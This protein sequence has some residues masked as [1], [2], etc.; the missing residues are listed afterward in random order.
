MAERPKRGVQSIYATG[1]ETGRQYIA[2]LERGAEEHDTFMPPPKRSHLKKK[3]FKE[4]EQAHEYEAD[5]ES[6]EEEDEETDDE[7]DDEEADV[8]EADDEECD[9][10]DESDNEEDEA[11]E[12]DK[13]NFLKNTCRAIW[14]KIT[15]S[16]GRKILA[17]D[18]YR[19]L[20]SLEAMRKHAKW[21]KKIQLNLISNA[22]TVDIVKVRADVL[23]NMMMKRGFA[24]AMTTFA[25][26]IDYCDDHH[27]CD[28]A[29]Y[30]PMKVYN[31]IPYRVD[32][33]L[34]NRE[35]FL[36]QGH[37]RRNLPE[38]TA[39]EAARKV[40]SQIG[41]LA[42]IQGYM[43]ASRLQKSAEIQSA[44]GKYKYAMEQARLGTR[45][46]AQHSKMTTARVTKDER[47]RALQVLLDGT[48]RGTRGKNVDLFHMRT[49]A[50][51][52]LE[53][54]II[55]R[56]QDIRSIHMAAMTAHTIDD[57]GPASCTAVCASI[58]H[59]K[60]NT[61][62]TEFVLSWISH[63]D[64]MQCSTIAIANYLVWAIDIYRL[65]ILNEMRRDLETQPAWINSGQRKDRWQSEWWSYRLVFGQDPKKELS[66]DIHLDGENTIHEAA[67]YQKKSKKTSL[68]RTNNAHIALERGM[69]TTDLSHYGGWAT[70]NSSAI[71][72]YIDTAVKVDSSMTMNGWENY[73]KYY[74]ARHSPDIPDAL[75][76]RIFPEL[77]ELHTLAKTTYETT[78]LDLSAV[79]FCEL[80]MYL[81][82]IFLEG[83]VDL[84]ARYPNLPP[85]VHPVFDTREWRV[86][87]RMEPDSRK[88]R[89]GKFKLREQDPNVIATLD[90]IH[91]NMKSMMD[92]L[93][94]AGSGAGL[95]G[96]TG[97]LVIDDTSADRMNVPVVPT[98]TTI[99][100][101]Y[102]FWDATLR[103]FL[104]R[105]YNRVSWKDRKEEAKRV[106]K[107]KP[108][109]LYID[110]VL[111]KSESDSETSGRSKIANAIIEKL[112]DIRKQKEASYSA[113]VY[114]F[115]VAIQKTKVH[116][117]NMPSHN[118]EEL[119]AAL[120][121][122]D[123]PTLPEGKNVKALCELLGWK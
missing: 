35:D 37:E 109:C 6:D 20:L 83:A 46:F 21:Y 11:T 14:P 100:A 32:H 92:K 33:I 51:K 90:K 7:S 74:C 115:K 45:D 4:Q 61:T 15:Q 16:R 110:Y 53:Q 42:E 68:P 78:Q 43:P 75:C 49:Y 91:D 54:N 34:K 8:E 79:K 62:N 80:L 94:I 52:Y 5:K 19:D 111:S 3:A 121:A 57:V 87:S 31:F 18:T 63:I 40:Q 76:R 95:Q 72:Y 38:E 108:F 96:Q 36:E 101:T 114:S 29:V 30:N 86:W 88:I 113:F 84:R 64:P 13:W 50:I 85:Y 67:G 102:R 122:H 25:I 82:R 28:Y 117:K 73:K 58:R 2:L 44:I 41:K 47:A 98:F 99:S 55:R 103:P 69:N 24:S 12:L 23:R 112:E 89:D 10:D 116:E 97:G 107:F 1:N 65:D 39:H 9:D 119:C 22:D 27:N 120:E 60:E 66:Y 59:V 81:R 106:D 26:W 48:I 77:D 17:Q 123:L 105:N 104:K 93:T 118:C 71:G 56:G 70:T